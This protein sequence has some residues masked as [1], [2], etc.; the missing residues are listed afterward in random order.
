MLVATSG[1]ITRILFLSAAVIIVF[2]TIAWFMF[3]ST[4]YDFRSLSFSCISLVRYIITG[5]PYGEMRQSSSVIEFKKK[6]LFFL[7]H[8]F[9]LSKYAPFIDP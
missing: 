9:K 4:I 7:F 8:F 5:L 3:S 2:G 6:T 1:A